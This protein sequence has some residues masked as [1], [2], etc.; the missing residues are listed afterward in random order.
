MFRSEVLTQRADRLAGNVSIA[1]PVAWQAV[2]YFLFV[3][4]IV[5]FAFL[6]F[7]TYS[8]VEVASGN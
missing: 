5:G 1:I 3:S 4:L 2:G 7:T 8:R 6:S